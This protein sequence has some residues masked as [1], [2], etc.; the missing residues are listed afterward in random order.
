MFLRM[1]SPV[2]GRSLLAGLCLLALAGN[3]TA[4]VPAAAGEAR[5]L[6]LAAHQLTQGGDFSARICA[7]AVPLLRASLEQWEKVPAAARDDV[8]PRLQ[9]G[10]CEITQGEHALA[11][12]RL[13]QLL[14]AP[15][16]PGNAL[17]ASEARIDLGDLYAAGLG[18]APDQEKALGLYLLA[19]PHTWQAHRHRDR[20]AAELVYKLNGNRPVELFQFLLER[21]GA[22]SN[23]LR[24]IELRRT[25]NENRYELVRL[26]IAALQ[27]AS[28]P[29]SDQ[30][31]A[32]ALQT[33]LEMAGQGLL[34]WGDAERLPA[35]IV[36]LQR[37]NRPAAQAAL[38]K[39]EK[40]LPH[41]LQLPDGS[42]WG[43]KND[44]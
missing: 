15:L 3:A 4:Q 21:G 5:R 24:S 41:R 42:Y 37:A 14:D 31:E 30:A 38:Q 18:V 9:L 25:G 1:F 7:E 28:F 22:P 8:Y 26:E 20:A 2:G 44:Q 27:A 16:A 13:R 34:D 39:L 23:W 10:R 17:L 32:A 29:S 36:Y 19:Q 35:A 33:L 6:F 12:G 43:P 11:A 40:K